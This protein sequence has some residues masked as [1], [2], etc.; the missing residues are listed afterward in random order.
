MDASTA[1]TF[2]TA[3]MF[4]GFSETLSANFAIVVPAAMVVFIAVWGL[5]KA[6]STFKSIIK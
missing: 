5:R 2:L 3:D 6:I 4:S 1:T